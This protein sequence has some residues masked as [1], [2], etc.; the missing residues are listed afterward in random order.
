MA[1]PCQTFTT[2]TKIWMSFREDDQFYRWTS[3]IEGEP[4]AGGE[5]ETNE[6]LEVDRA[7]GKF[8]AMRTMYD[9]YSGVDEYV[10]AYAEGHCAPE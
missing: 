5:R 2:S 7:T 10:A 4:V 9:S 1:M 6:A 8:N 3:R